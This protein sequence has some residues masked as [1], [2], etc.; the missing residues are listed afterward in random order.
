VVIERPPGFDFLVESGQTTWKVGIHSFLLD[1]QRWKELWRTRRQVCLLFPWESHLTGCLCFWV[2]RHVAGDSK[3]VKV[4]LLSPGQVTLTNKRASTS[5]KYMLW[6]IRF[7]AYS[8]HN[9]IYQKS[10][11]DISTFSHGRRKSGTRKAVAPSGFSYILPLLCFSTSTCFV[12]TSQLPPTIFV[13]C[14]Q[15]WLT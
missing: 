9:L 5:A 15:R 10:I 8:Q 4:S 13:L 6:K 2:A 3:T 14:M 11:T 12:K 1:V 7:C